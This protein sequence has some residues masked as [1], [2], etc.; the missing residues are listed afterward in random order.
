MK[1]TLPICIALFALVF[2][3]QGCKTKEEKAA[4]K[5]LLSAEQGAALAQFK[6]G[7]MYA[8]GEGVPE[9]KLYAY[10]WVNA[11]D[12]QGLGDS[13]SEYKSEL[14]KQMTPTQ[15]E[16]AEKLYAECKEKS[17]KSC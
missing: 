3:I 1:S 17:Y 8:S 15:I 5:A 9:D 13:A 7:K 6:L 10:M 4:N 16:A 12:I 11:A 14:V 2:V